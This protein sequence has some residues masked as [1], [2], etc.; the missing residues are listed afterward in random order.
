MPFYSGWGL[1]EDKFVNKE[2]AKRRKRNLTLEEIVYIAIIEYPHYYS[3][4][5]KC[6]SEIEDIINE[7]DQNY[8]NK[9]NF[10]QFIFRYWGYF[11]DLLK[12]KDF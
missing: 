11:K 6:I 7:I 8:N 10:E 3:L 4:K 5:F 1:T 12:K 2:M 9:K